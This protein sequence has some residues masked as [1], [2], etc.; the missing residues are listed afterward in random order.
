M[1]F[2]CT[3]IVASIPSFLK[4]NVYMYIIMKDKGQEGQGTLVCKRDKFRSQKT[5]LSVLFIGS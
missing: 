3:Q 5:S 2:L 1:K 4:G